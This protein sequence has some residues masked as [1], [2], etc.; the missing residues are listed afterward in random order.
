MSWGHRE[1]ARSPLLPSPSWGHT[2]A[3]W[4]T[5]QAGKSMPGTWQVLLISRINTELKSM[6]RS[7]T[8]P[9]SVMWLLSQKDLEIGI[10]SC[11]ISCWQGTYVIPVFHNLLQNH[12]WYLIWFLSSNEQSYMGESCRPPALSYS[13]EKAEHP[14]HFLDF[15]LWKKN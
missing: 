2:E 4:V 3:G 5:G 15:S 6:Y 14:Q 11:E 7:Q 12:S 10:D 9:H 8:Q 1:P 13:S